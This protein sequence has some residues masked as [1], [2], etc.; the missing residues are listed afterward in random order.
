MKLLFKLTFL[1]TIIMVIFT[2][3]STPSRDDF[4]NSYWKFYN[5]NG[6]LGLIRFQA[7]GSISNYVSNN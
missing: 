6:Y 7:N 5:D 1:A 2:S 3:A 4:I